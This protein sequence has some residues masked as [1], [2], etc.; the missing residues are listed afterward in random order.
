VRRSLWPEQAAQPQFIQYLRQ[1]YDETQ[2][3]AIE[4]L[5]DVYHLLCT[6]CS[7]PSC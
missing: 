6:A 4:V 3:E 7:V 5:P 1:R 2:L